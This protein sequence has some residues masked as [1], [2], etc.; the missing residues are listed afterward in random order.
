MFLVALLGYLLAL[1]IEVWGAFGIERISVEKNALRLTR[2]AWRRTRTWNIAFSDI[3]E[4][5][6]ITPWYRM[7]NSVE[8][9]AARKYLKI[10]DRLQ[11]DEALELAQALRHTVGLTK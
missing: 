10:G 9:N 8:V 2:T 3:T 5:K 1:A 11:R 6:A 4:V 7:D